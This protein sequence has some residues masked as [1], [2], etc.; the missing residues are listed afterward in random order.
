VFEADQEHTVSKFRKAFIKTCNE[1]REKNGVDELTDDEEDV[2]ENNIKDLLDLMIYSLPTLKINAK[3]D[4]E[5]VA[6]IFVRVNSGGQ[7]L[8]EKN[9]IETLLA[10]YD[11]DVH[12]KINKFCAVS[13]IPADKT[14]FNQIIQLDPA[15]LIRM[16]VGVGFKRA[17]L[18]YAYMLLRGKI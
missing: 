10:V 16:A 17:R 3:A 15:H 2:I 14:S 4:E 13:R 18:K 9:F 7:K 5:D 1:G 8:T 6:D 12:D 11:N